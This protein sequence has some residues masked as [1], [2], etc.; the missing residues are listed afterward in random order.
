V[1]FLTS[2]GGGASLYRTLQRDYVAREQSVHHCVLFDL[3]G[4]QVTLRAI[5]VAGKEIDRFVLTKEPTPPDEFC[6][7]EAE[8]FKKLFRL[9]LAGAKPVRIPD[10]EAGEIDST[11]Q[12]PT[13]FQVPV[14]GQLQWQPAPGWKL[15]Q[16]VVD[17]KLQPG[18]A[19]TIPLQATVAAGAFPRNPAPTVTFEPGRFHNRT[20]EVAPFQLGGPGRVAVPHTDQK[21]TVDG[22]LDEPAWQRGAGHALLGVP[23]LGGRLDQVRLLADDDWLYVAAR[24]DDPDGKVQV[25]TG[26]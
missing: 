1:L 16:P 13:R 4:D 22:K 20:V 6:A 18:E 10:R 21:V 23:P 11:L 5:D 14:A 12:V 9:A 25:E 19:L 2:A 26:P 3:D 17:F 24:L 8:E 7:F 15:K